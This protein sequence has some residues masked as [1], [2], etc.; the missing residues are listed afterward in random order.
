ME[1][2]YFHYFPRHMHTTHTTIP[3]SSLLTNHG[4]PDAEHTGL[5]GRTF[6]R[7]ALRNGVCGGWQIEL[8]GT[9]QVV[10]LSNMTIRTGKFDNGEKN[11]FS[12]HDVDH[13]V[14]LSAYQFL[15]KIGLQGTSVI[16]PKFPQYVEEI[17]LSYCPQLDPD[18]DLSSYEHLQKINLASSGVASPK[19]PQ[20]V[21]RIDLKNCNNLFSVIDLSHCKQ[22]S[23]VV[24]SGTEV[25]SM[26]LPDRIQEVELAGCKDLPTELDLSTYKALKK[27][28]LTASAVETVYVSPTQYQKHIDGAWEI[29]G[30]V[31]LKVKNT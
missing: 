11:M 24:L 9:D 5:P 7:K 22:L 16:N 29:L 8:S 14:D 27:V 12:Q 19:F 21:E 13:N 1:K 26:K 18:L 20:Q 31:V 4:N 28:N 10:G 23:C 2:L 6:S 25:Y 3:L 17:D 15:K 30:E